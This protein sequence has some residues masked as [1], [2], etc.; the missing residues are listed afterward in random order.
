MY[1][2]KFAY[3]VVPNQSFLKIFRNIRLKINK[4]YLPKVFFPLI[5]I[6]PKNRLIQIPDSIADV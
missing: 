5:A 2:T 3:E 4:A 1:A 6:R